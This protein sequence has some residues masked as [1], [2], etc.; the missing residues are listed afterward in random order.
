MFL[1]LTKEMGIMLL[2]L[3][4]FGISSII[5]FIDGELERKRIQ[6]FLKQRNEDAVIQ[7]IETTEE[8]P[9]EN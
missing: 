3:P 7:N 5:Q 2:L 9:H 1:I 8:E 6:K 4:L